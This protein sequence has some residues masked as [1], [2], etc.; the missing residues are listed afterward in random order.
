MFFFGVLGV[1]LL[2]VV[3]AD[4]FVT[5]TE[6]EAGTR[7]GQTTII[8]DA[9]AS[10]GQ[11]IRFGQTV[12]NNIKPTIVGNSLQIGTSGTMLKLHG[13]C[14]WGLQDNVQQ[15]EAGEYANRV[16]IVNNIKAW[17]A[18][19]VRFQLNSPL[20]YGQDAAGK[21]NQLQHMKEW[22]D[23]VTG[24]GM[25]FHIA[26]WDA[27]NKNADWATKYGETFGVMTDVFNTLGND[28]MV[29]YEPFNEP[30][31]VSVDQWTN[32]FKAT[33]NHFRTNLGYTGILAL[34]TMEWSNFY[35]D[36]AMTQLEQYDASFKGMNGKHQIVFAKHDYAQYGNPDP[37][38]TF[39][40][41]RWFRG[42]TA[43]GSSGWDFK[44]HLVWETEFGNEVDGQQRLIW[45]AGA[46]TWMADKLNDGTLV[47]ATA[48]LYGPWLDTN[49]MTTADYVTPTQWGNSVK[50][51]FLARVR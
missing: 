49:A 31:G 42:S 34:D 15:F 23:L 17:G 29:V 48:F 30:H 38:Q 16:K 21:A 45:S 14:V 27:L 6:A 24:A 25:Y 33:I 44:K 40:I 8:A 1:F 41:D 12:G 47:G 51:N 13:V 37:N 11:A 18:N 36:G 28:P 35:N 9:A 26:W 43:G 19:E 46:A 39:N 5:S 2:Y 32:A 50:N 22:R 20:Y 7:N 4:T 10:Q 3:H